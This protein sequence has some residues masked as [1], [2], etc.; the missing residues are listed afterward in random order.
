MYMKTGLVDILPPGKFN[1]F[2]IAPDAAEANWLVGLAGWSQSTHSRYHI[3]FDNAPI[4]ISAYYIDNLRPQAPLE[5][6]TIPIAS[7]YMCPIDWVKR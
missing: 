5:P 3:D 1:F 4:L 6:S 7:E 2:V